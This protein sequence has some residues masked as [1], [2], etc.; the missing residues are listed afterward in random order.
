MDV[1]AIP[2]FVFFSVLFVYTGQRLYKLHGQ[3]TGELSPRLYWMS[4]HTFLTYLLLGIGAVGTLFLGVKLVW[5]SAFNG[6]LLSFCGVLSLFYVVP[7]RRRSLRQIPF[8]K[9]GLV[10]GTFWLVAC[11]LPVY[12]RMFSFSPA[13]SGT[14]YLFLWY[15]LLYIFGLTMLFDIPD[16]KIDPSSQR[17]FPQFIGVRG[18]VYLAILFCLPLL[19]LFVETSTSRYGSGSLVVLHVLFFLGLWKYKERRFYILFFAEGMLGLMG[20]Y[21]VFY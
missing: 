11:F 13:L 21:F 7:F 18:T 16:L 20:G 1:Q 19:L 2:F 17:T 15:S 5:N 8:L 12:E 10:T 14:L 3:N 6:V 4:Q 9:T